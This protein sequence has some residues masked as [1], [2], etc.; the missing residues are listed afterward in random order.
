MTKNF[1]FHDSSSFHS[2]I[3]LSNKKFQVH[4][5]EN[6]VAGTSVARI[7]ATDDDSGNYGTSSIRYTS[8]HGSIADK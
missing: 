1:F 4:I 3:N 8:L 7:E 2:K 5:A 6:A